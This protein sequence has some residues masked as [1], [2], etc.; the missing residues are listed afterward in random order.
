MSRQGKEN[1]KLT[2]KVIDTLPPGSVGGTW[3]SD[4]DLRG[5][6][7]VCYATG[8]KVFF[9]R[10][11]T[12]A[13]K[14]DVV[15]LGRFGE[16]TAEEARDK[17]R[18][19][20]SRAALGG[21]PAQERREARRMP[22][23]G[24]WCEAYLERVA[25]KKKSAREDIRFLATAAER[26]RTRPLDS[27]TRED[28]VS[29]HQHMHGRPALANRWLA[30]VS[31][32]LSEAVRSGFITVNPA[33]GIRH[34]REKPPRSRV[35]SEAE[36]QRLVSA[37]ETTEDPFVRVGFLVLVTL[38]PRVSELLN[39]RWND[40]DFENRLWRLPSTK[41]GRPQIIPL[42]DRSLEA[43][44]ALPRAGLFVIPGPKGRRYDLRK[45]WAALRKR[46]SL[47]DDITLHD[48]RRTAG[49]HFARAAGLHVASRIL[50]HSSVKVTESVYAPLG[51]DELRKAIQDRAEVLPFK[52]A[53]KRRR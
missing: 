17:A 7:V 51:V 35:L 9:A 30:S 18:E 19:V 49:L 12:P 20:L 3:H 27:I 26:W 13:G 33:R 36:M 44:R 40:L 8:A 6:Y 45:P 41:A 24:E 23:F 52:K 31:S 43:L 22:T 2:K 42:D 50:R 37:I 32:A 5:F 4:S 53:Q 46:A 16:L 34:H 25:S 28:V 21:D 39:A 29:F 14:R 15:R 47:P 38:G 48:L 1:R 10:Y 11:R